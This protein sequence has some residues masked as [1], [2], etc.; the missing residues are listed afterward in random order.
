[1]NKEEILQ[2]VD[3]AIEILRPYLH[4]DGGDLKAVDITSE[5]VLMLQAIGTCHDCRHIELTLQNG[6]SEAILKEIPIIKE[7]KIID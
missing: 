5:M 4:A 2:K 1:M 7:I 3:S 6:I